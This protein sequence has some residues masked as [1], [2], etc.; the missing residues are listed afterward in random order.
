M[1]ITRRL[2]TNNNKKDERTAQ[3]ELETTETLTKTTFSIYCFNGQ[4]ISHENSCCLFKL[5]MAR[6]LN[7][8][9]Y[10][11]CALFSLYFWCQLLSNFS[12][13]QRFN[14]FLLFS[15]FFIFNS[16]G[17]TLDN[18]KSLATKQK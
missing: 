17:L 8:R 10:F 18:N 9:I 15:F 12:L 6:A 11:C 13:V 4:T 7:S 1:N 16:H 14:F 2:H 5:F 3:K